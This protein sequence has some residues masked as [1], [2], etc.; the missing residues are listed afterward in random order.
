MHNACLFKSN[1]ERLG[2]ITKQ[3]KNEK[4]EQLT[5]EQCQLLLMS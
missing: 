2:A 5:K 4:G 1:K 3:T